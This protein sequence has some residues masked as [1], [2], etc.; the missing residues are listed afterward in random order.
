MTVENPVDPGQP[1]LDERVQQLA[2]AVPHGIVLLQDATVVWANDR[3]ETMAGR[4]SPLRGMKISDLLEDSGDGLPESDTQHDLMCALPR[5]TGNVRTVICRCAWPEHDAQPAAWSIEDV[6]HVQQLERELMRMGQDLSEANRELAELRGELRGARSEREELLAV[7][8]HE[9]RTPLTIITGFNRLLGSEETGVLTD[10][11]KHFV[12]EIGKGCHR[13]DRF[14]SNLLQA[15]RIKKGD[16]VLEL[17]AASVTPVIEGVVAMFRPMLD[18]NSLKLELDIDRAGS[19]ARFD[20]ARVEQILNNLVG[21]AIR[22]ASVEG[23]IEI[24]VRAI[25]VAER[26]F[27]EIS[28]ADDGP[29]ISKNDRERIF[30]PYVQVGEES[31][32]GGLGLGLAICKQLVEAHGGMLGVEDRPGGGSRF[33]FTLPAVPTATSGRDALQGE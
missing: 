3:M 15:S 14:I 24:C 33:F 21:N 7:V 18:E 17:G 22:Y 29:G 25:D 13:I 8:S 19:G 1:P 6:S 11:Q 20:R 27:V 4:R 30:R 12:D 23:T 26:R 28:I 5:D 10:E 16:V 32:A 9:L 31:R 2:A